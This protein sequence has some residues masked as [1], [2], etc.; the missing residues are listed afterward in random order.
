MDRLEAFERMLADIKKQADDENRKMA[1]LKAA[2]RE[3][4]ATCR[5]YF[6]SRMLYKLILDRYRQYGLLDRDGEEEN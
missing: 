5:Q 1:E 3:K 4:S 6:S 2:G